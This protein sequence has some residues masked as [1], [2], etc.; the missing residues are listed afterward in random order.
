MYILSNRMTRI[1]TNKWRQTLRCLEWKAKQFV[2]AFVAQDVRT[3][4]IVV[5]ELNAQQFAA[6]VA[7]VRRR[8]RTLLR[9]RLERRHV[10]RI[11]I[12]L[13]VLLVAL[14]LRLCSRLLLLFLSASLL[15][16][17]SLP[18]IVFVLLPPL[19]FALLVLALS[20][21]LLLFTLACA[22]FFTQASSCFFFR[23]TLSPVLCVSS[24][25]KNS[26]TPSL[27]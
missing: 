5:F 14:R 10:K 2:V 22:L 7:H 13:R 23:C 4:G 18:S 15:L 1:H 24:P 19:T 11:L 3:H 6:I 26:Q 17:F 25:T 8:F 20:L 16:L 9:R 21:S 12:L 27:S